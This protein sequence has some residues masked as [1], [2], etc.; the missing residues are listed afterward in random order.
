MI[1]IG[2]GLNIKKDF[3]T[4]EESINIW[5]SGINLKESGDK[6]TVDTPVP[7]PNTEVKHSSGEGSWLACENST[8]P[9]FFFICFFLCVF[10]TVFYKSY[11]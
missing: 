10:L 8:L 11:E 9:G 1:L 3:R 5:F 2:R 4:L 7:I 6:G